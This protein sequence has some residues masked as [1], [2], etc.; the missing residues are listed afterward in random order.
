MNEIISVSDLVSHIKSVLDSDIDLSR[1]VVSGEISNYTH[2][3]SGHLY[4]TLKDNKS[5]IRCVMF[6]SYAIRNTFEPKNGDKVIL[7]GYVSVFE[8]SG[9]LQMYV[10]KLEHD[11]LGDLYKKYEELKKRLGNEGYFNE[12]HKKDIPTLYP[13]KVAVLVGNDSAAMSDIRNAFSNRWPI[14]KV[15][16]YP[17]PVQGNSAHVD[18]INTLEK[19]DKLDYQIII[20]SRGGG[21][22]EDYAPFNTEELVKCIYNLNTFIVSGVGH[23]RDF[24][25]VDFVADLRGSTPT[26]AVEKITPKINE[27]YDDVLFNEDRLI[28]LINEK[29]EENND[30]LNELMNNK[31]FLEPKSLLERPS[32]LFAY[33]FEKLQS[34]NSKFVELDNTNNNYIIRMKELILNKINNYKNDIDNNLKTD[35]IYINHLLEN[36]KLLLKRYSTLLEAYSSNNV[37]S[38]GYSL[39]YKNDKLIKTIKDIKVNDE[40][41]IKLLD[42]N[43][44]TNVKEV[45]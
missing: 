15:D 5:Q 43:I 44:L 19:V 36:N 30:L 45:K 16:Y 29:I 34:F 24:S 8:D 17:V 1:V 40:L 10:N 7:N 14:C 25:L 35:A 26:Q 13:E 27:V 6:K 33:Y 28:T 41:D 21:S 31:Y 22:F 3:S 18:I 23:E 4:F 37:L 9:S 38:R 11:G 42:G 32:L 2:H 20:L 39:V 12:D